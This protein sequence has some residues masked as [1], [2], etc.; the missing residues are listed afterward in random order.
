M[1]AAFMTAIYFAVVFVTFFF[2]VKVINFIHR[3]IYPTVMEGDRFNAT[4]IALIAGAIPVVFVIG[5][6]VIFF[7][8]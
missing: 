5:S 3:R 4:R 1:F 2:V 7:L 6:F 8:S